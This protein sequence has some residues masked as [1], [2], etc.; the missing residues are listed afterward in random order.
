MYIMDKIDMSGIIDIMKDLTDIE[1]DDVT[2]DHVLEHYYISAKQG[3]LAYCLVDELPS[4]YD[5]VFINY[6]V[7]LYINRKY[8]GVSH[9][10]QGERSITLESGLPKTIKDSLPLPKVKVRG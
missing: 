10:K 8:I 7:Y 4:K 1:V 2:K 3:I 6:G 9:S 5:S